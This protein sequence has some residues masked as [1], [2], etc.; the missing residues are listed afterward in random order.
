MYNSI[1]PININFAKKNHFQKNKE[2]DSN[3]AEQKQSTSVGYQ[4][5][6]NQTFP[7]GT[8]VAI[9]YTKGHINITQV[10]SD[11]K[12][13]VVAINAPDDIREEVYAY[14]D[15]V[16]KEAKKQNPSRQI[17]LSNLKN[18]SYI[19]DGYIASALKKPSDVVL[20]WIET[21]F[22]QNINLKADYNEI[23][24]DFKLVFPKGAK[25]SSNEVDIEQNNQNTPKNIEDNTK[26]DEPKQSAISAASV[27]SKDST[28]ESG[29]I[30][31]PKPIEENNTNNNNIVQ[32][33][34]IEL[35]NV[36]NEDVTDE[37]LSNDEIAYDDVS[38]NEYNDVSKTQT[39]FS[40]LCVEDIKAKEL[41]TKAKSMPSNNLGDTQALNLLNDALG[42]IA[43]SEN[44]NKNIKAALHIERG[45]IFDNYDYVDYALRD[46]FEATKADD[47]N[48]KAQAFYKSA[49][50][51]DEFSQFYPALDNYLSSVA[52]SGQAENYDAQTR[53]LLKVSNLYSKKYDYQNAREYADLALDT[54]QDTNDAKLI[55]NTYSLDAQNSLEQGD[56]ERAL[57]SF[58]NALS[59]FFKTDE[60]YEQMAYNYEQASLVMEKLGNR[61]KAAKLQAKAELYYQK[62]Q[63]EPGQLAKAS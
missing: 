35:S 16:E 63:L 40:P 8:K 26:I 10:I 28:V 13:T 54:A 24:E 58:K 59:N 55:A 15:L 19:T 62:A 37:S 22:L 34:D 3:N 14:L 36:V 30:I 6:Q 47:Y 23:N 27:Q 61:A 45:K 52:Y 41:F 12:S 33:S 7:N 51:Y 44:S 11:F 57:N 50:L 31:T 17:V 46:Y 32:Q 4:S 20:K 25:T 38:D 9:D 48:L 42:I 39:P 53:V 2:T 56:N 60:S 5:A 29:I 43:N 49:L 1:Y 18:A 21:L